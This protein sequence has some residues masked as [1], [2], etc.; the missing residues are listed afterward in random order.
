MDP[1][2]KVWYIY[3][4]IAVSFTSRRVSS[5]SRAL[6][7][8]SH[9]SSFWYDGAISYYFWF[10]CI[11][12]CSVG[13]QRQ[14]FCT[15]LWIKNKQMIIMAWPEKSMLH[16]HSKVPTKV[17]VLIHKIRCANCPT[18]LIVSQQATCLYLIYL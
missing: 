7:K 3:S 11:D 1:S 4:N 18:L 12:G 10:A 14:Y 13:K 5:Y 15:N 17:G 16:Q 6:N 9:S 8:F 2:Q